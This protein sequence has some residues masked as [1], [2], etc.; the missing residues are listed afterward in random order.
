MEALL[1]LIRLGFLVSPQAG[2]GGVGGGWGGVE[3]A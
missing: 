2:M 1:T 3:S